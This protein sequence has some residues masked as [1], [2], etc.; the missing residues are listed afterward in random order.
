M[1]VP[2]EHTGR[3]GLL[4]MVKNLVLADKSNPEKRLVQKLGSC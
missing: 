2:Q 1:S 4:V 3:H